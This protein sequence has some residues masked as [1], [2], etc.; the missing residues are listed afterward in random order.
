[1]LIKYDIEIPIYGGILAILITDRDVYIHDH[2]DDLGECN[3]IEYAHAT[4]VNIKKG[5]QF[6]R[7]YLI[8]FNIN[9]KYAKITHGTIGH[10][11]VHSAQIILESIGMK[12]KKN[13][14]EAYAYLA[15]WIIDRVYELFEKNK[16]KIYLKPK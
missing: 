5:K 7:A 13:S 6:R 16:I 11:A 10:E 3:L 15:Q 1:M 4:Y 12:L 8:A 2:Y 14:S 9:N